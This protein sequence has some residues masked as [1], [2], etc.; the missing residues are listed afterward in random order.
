MHSQLYTL[1]IVYHVLYDTYL[2]MHTGISVVYFSNIIQIYIFINHRDWKVIDLGQIDGLH[3][4][5]SSFFTQ[6]IWI[7]HKYSNV[8]NDSARVCGILLVY[9]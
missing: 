3:I 5:H 8:L 4:I 9:T 2:T 1:G 6:L 7:Q